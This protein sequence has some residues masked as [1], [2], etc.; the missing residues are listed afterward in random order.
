VDAFASL[1]AREATVDATLKTHLGMQHQIA[2]ADI[3][4]C[5]KRATYCYAAPF[6]L[7]VLGFILPDFVG[8]AFLLTLLPSGLAGLF[9]TKRGLSL[10]TRSG[11]REK[12]DVG[13][14][15]LI[16]GVIILVLGLLALGLISGL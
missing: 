2:R 9:F 10:S 12:K 13:Y 3:V 16:L 14:A 5:Y 7:M 8:A 11:D 6:C 15:N 1:L 4:S